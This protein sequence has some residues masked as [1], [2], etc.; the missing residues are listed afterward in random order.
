MWEGEPPP[1]WLDEGGGGGGGRGRRAAA[2]REQERER[3]GEAP[4]AQGGK[5][6]EQLRQAGCDVDGVTEQFKAR[7]DPFFAAASAIIRV[8][9]ALATE[10]RRGEQRAPA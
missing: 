4:D 7:L 10:G 6:R 1:G 3:D 9:P 5:L 2:R 8:I